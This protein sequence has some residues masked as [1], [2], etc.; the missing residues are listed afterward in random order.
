M[1]KKN[2]KAII[3]T[4]LITLSP[5]AIGLIMW[6]KLPDQIATHFGANG[7]PDQYSSKAFAVFGLPL[8]MLAIHVVCV[9][10]TNLDP[11]Y[12]NITDKNFK[13]VIWITPLLSLL[14]C[15]LCFAY[16]I[17]NTLPVVTILIIFMGILFVIIGNLM[18]KV[19]QNYS[20]GIKI[21]PTLH[22]KENWYKTHRFAGKIWVAGG[23]VIC[24]TAVFENIFVFMAITLVIA[25][26]PMVYSYAIANGKNEKNNKE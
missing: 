22:D 19:K 7:I 18:P 12:G 21:P 13:L 1:I 9:L 17:N 24:L 4:A 2:L 15:V 5:I 14:L 23:V 11:K 10:A 3:T 25:F 26:A 6:D 20:L 8:I 16:S